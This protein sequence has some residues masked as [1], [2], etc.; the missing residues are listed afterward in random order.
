MQVMRI[1]IAVLFLAAGA[2]AALAQTPAKGSTAAAAPEI[3]VTSPAAQDPGV[4]PSAAGT[5]VGNGPSSGVRQSV[6]GGAEHSGSKNLSA[7]T[8]PLAAAK[9]NRQLRK[10]QQTEQTLQREIGGA[11]QAQ[12]GSGSTSGR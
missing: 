6:K 9:A 5:Q 7:N 3:P 8:H 1:A 11:G 4:N 10:R 12:Q 2:G